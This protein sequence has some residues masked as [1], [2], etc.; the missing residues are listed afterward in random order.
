MRD[1]KTDAGR[2]GT[3]LCG[4]LGAAWTC[5][6]TETEAPATLGRGRRASRWSAQSSVGCVGM[7]KAEE[8]KKLSGSYQGY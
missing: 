5:A 4:C 6:R 7:R 2:R 3:W 1:A 8:T